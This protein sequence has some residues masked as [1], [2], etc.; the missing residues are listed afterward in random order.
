MNEIMIQELI[1]CALNELCR[2]NLCGDTI[3][4]YQSCAFKPIS[5]FYKKKGENYYSSNLTE[6]LKKLYQE[7]YTLGYISHKTVNWRMRGI[8]ILEEIYKCGC[9]E[10]KVFSKKKENMLSSYYDGILSRFIASLGDIKRINIYQSISQRYFLYISINGHDKFN[11]VACI[12]IKNFM[13]E[14]SGSRPKSMDDVVAVLKQL[15]YYLRNNGYTC[16]R[17]EPVLFSPRARDKK[18]IPCISVDE[19]WNVAE[20]VNLETPSG[21]RDNA[22]LQL[23]IHT[24]LRAGDIANLRL[25]DID[26][27]NSEI[28]L[29]QGKTQG[30]LT[31]PLDAH[32]GAAL[33]DYILNGRPK[34]NSPYMFLRSIAPYNKFKN[35][36]S[37][38]CIFR[39]Y[40]KKAGLSHF[41]G[42]GR[43]FHG[44]RRTLGTEM[45][46]Q[47]VPVTTVSQVLGHR[48]N[49]AARQ[50]ISLNIKDLR[51]C[52]LEFNSID[53]GFR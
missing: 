52:A 6:E 7:E 39:K 9:F 46:I 13:I 2:L 23:E 16:I 14:I 50:Y 31:L 4:S 37:I 35:G 24:G 11:N 44:I 3:D 32:A 5:N 42:D 15:H 40:L 29:I 12:D 30:Q 36:V 21:K 8:G 48:T 27:K 20:Q 25:I 17:F 38:A 41:E 18:I 49:N 51:Q 22:I 45:V 26:W 1:N 47:G 10:W 19:I 34:S 43:T 53:G 28:R 33:I